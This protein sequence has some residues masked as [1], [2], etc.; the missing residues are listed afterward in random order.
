[1]SEKTVILPYSRALV[2]GA[3]SGLGSELCKLLRSGGCKTWGISRDKR[4]IATS[5]VIPIELDLSNNGALKAFI[6][7]E[8]TEIAPDLLV[9][10]AGSGVFGELEEQTEA[11]IRAQIDVMLT[12]PALLCRAALPAMKAQRHG[13]IANVSSMA[14]DF[15]LPC[16]PLYNAAK[17]G[18]SALGRTI[19]G[20]LEGNGIIVIDFRPGDFTSGFLKSTRRVGGKNKAWNVAGKHIEGA[21]DAAWMARRLLEAIANGKGGTI[22]AGTFFQTKLAPLGAKILPKAIFGKLKKQYLG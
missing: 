16:M 17:A 21:P 22:R 11:D 5:G 3:S 13:C 19:E 2:T 18:L 4:R 20:D 15:P 10:C 6:E 12:S 8:L 7:G 1:M 14:A 9:N